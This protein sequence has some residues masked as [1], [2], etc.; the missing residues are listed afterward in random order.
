[1]SEPNARG[2]NVRPPN[3]GAKVSEARI[4]RIYPWGVSTYLR[5]LA[6]DVVSN[7]KI[8]LSCCH[9]IKIDVVIADAE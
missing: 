5:P 4:P 8:S 1:M 9:I 3:Q 7:L 2:D 6:E